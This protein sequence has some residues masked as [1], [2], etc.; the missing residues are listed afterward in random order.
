MLFSPALPH[1]TQLLSTALHQVT[2]ADNQL[3]ALQDFPPSSCMKQQRRKDGVIELDTPVG[4]WFNPQRACT[5][6]TSELPP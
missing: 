1:T 4:P 5:D 6:S 3:C 2:H